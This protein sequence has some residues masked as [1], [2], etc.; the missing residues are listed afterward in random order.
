MMILRNIEILDS[1]IDLG[2]YSYSEVLL[3]YIETE[4]ALQHLAST[5]GILKYFASS[6]N[7]WL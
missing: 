5:Y 3:G 7:Q 6:G 1:V 4:A 2:L